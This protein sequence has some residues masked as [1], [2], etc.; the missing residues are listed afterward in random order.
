MIR[1]V[2]DESKINKITSVARYIVCGFLAATEGR[3]TIKGFFE[4]IKE[5]NDFFSELILFHLLT[6]LIISSF[7][8]FNVKRARVEKKVKYFV[9]EN[10]VEPVLIVILFV[11][12]IL[13]FGR[14]VQLFIQYEVGLFT[15][16]SYA[17]ILA[18]MIYL[19]VREIVYS[20]RDKSE[21]NT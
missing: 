5:T 16:F 1:P 18:I 20:K 14:M 7:I 6:V 15:L 11:I 21:L 2:K 10:R 19:F 12:L 9:P 8:F 13:A 3:K 4:T 17:V